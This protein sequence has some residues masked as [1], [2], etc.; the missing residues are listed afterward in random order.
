MRKLRQVQR[1][2]KGI[3]MKYLVLQPN[4]NKEARKTKP[5]ILASS[6]DMALDRLYGKGFARF[7]S[8]NS[9]AQIEGGK[10]VTKE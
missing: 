9:V 2:D 4:P 10:V 6:I 1:N 3:D 7:S 5:Y 8:R